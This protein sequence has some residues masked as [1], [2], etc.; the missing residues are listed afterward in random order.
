MKPAFTNVVG[1]LALRERLYHDI[2]GGTL[3]HAYILEGAFGTGKHTVALNIAAALACERRDD[4]SG[5]FPCRICPA[6][7]KILSGN[8]P[9]V[10]FINKGDKATLGVEAIRDLRRDVLIAPNDVS[11]KVYIF[12][13][14]HL[15]TVQAQNALLLTLE[16][17]PPYVLFLLLCESTA[18]LLETVRSRAPT[19]RT[20]PLSIQ[21]IDEY[22][23]KHAID[24]PALKRS[25]PHD[26]SE[27]L[28]AANGSIGNALALLDSKARKPILAAR[29]HAREF[30]RLCK[31]RKSSA[32]A[33]RLMNALGQRRDELCTS[34][35]LILL[36]LRDLLVSKQTEEAPLC[37]FTD[38]EEALTLAYSFTT[39][40]LLRLCD[41]ITDTIS[42]LR[43]N[44][45]VRLCMTA[46][47]VKAGLL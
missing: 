33:L 1:N 9:D 38:R 23:E 15:M 40:E 28:I 16:E 42:Q 3:S 7:R 26:Y 2:L 32:A 35:E 45:N 20:E 31:T 18:P 21:T 30:A 24:A 29:E 37:F 34:L 43:A 14:A 41:C 12:E 13:E 8:S 11:A 47:A 27:I 44:A 22:L 46:L 5:T 39:P 25:A 4:P 17:P 6:C 36:C 10:S 19:L